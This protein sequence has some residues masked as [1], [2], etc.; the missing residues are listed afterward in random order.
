[1]IEISS[2]IQEIDEVLENYLVLKT[3]EHKNEFLNK[4]LNVFLFDKCEGD[5]SEYEFNFL[6]NH[7]I[8]G[9]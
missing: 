7:V 9:I 4:H 2:S 3:Y 5:T 1:M 6:A 8:N